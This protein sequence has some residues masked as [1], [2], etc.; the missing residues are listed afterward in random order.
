MRAGF[1]S[2]SRR[3]TTLLRWLR[4]TDVSSDPPPASGGVFNLIEPTR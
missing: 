2:L 1:Y 3:A 4:S